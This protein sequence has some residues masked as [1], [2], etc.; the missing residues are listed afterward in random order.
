[1]AQNGTPPSAKKVF[2]K[3]YAEAA[4]G[5]SPEGQLIG[6][7][8]DIFRRQRNN[9]I[10]TEIQ[11][12]L[13]DNQRVLKDIDLSNTPQ[14][15]IYACAAFAIMGQ[16]EDA[17]KF[18]DI[19]FKSDAVWAFFSDGDKKF[20]KLVLQNAINQITFHLGLGHRRSIDLIARAMF[21]TSDPFLIGDIEKRCKGT[22]LQAYG[23]DIAMKASKIF[24]DDSYVAQ[25]AINLSD[26]T[27][28]ILTLENFCVIFPDN[29]VMHNT[30]ANA[31]IHDD[32][33][34]EAVRLL[35]SK[36]KDFPDNAV[37]HN[38]LANAYIHDDR[39]AEAVRLLVS[40]IK[41]FPDNAVMHATLANAYIHDNRPAEAVRLLAP[42]IKDFPDNA[43]MHNTLANAYIHDGRP[44]E[45]VRLLAPRIKDFPD[46]AVMHTTLANAYIHDNRPA[47][48]VQLL[49]PRIKDFPD[50]AVMHTTLAMC[51][52]EAKMQ[53]IFDA[54]KPK[55]DMPQAQIDYLDAKIAYLSNDVQKAKSI[56]KPYIFEQ[57]ECNASSL[58]LY[59]ACIGN[60][61]GIHALLPILK[62]QYTYNYLTQCRDE[63]REN[64][65]RDMVAD[66][67][68]TYSSSWRI[69]E[70]G[71]NAAASRGDR[72][73]AS[74]FA[75][76]GVK[77]SSP[78][79]GRTLRL[80][81]QGVRRPKT[82]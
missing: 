80:K 48:A 76:V 34:A 57:T 4:F 73:S 1:M 74:F 47:K 55:L 68:D 43:V 63:W 79:S 49:A 2:E 12:W 35:V 13:R 40:K 32:R 29:A 42:R 58:G 10:R 11:Q 38:T 56:L 60:D 71:V 5:N 61:A 78:S 54:I 30:L 67:T 62:G 9:D 70:Q 46:N 59:L 24:P 53:T 50:G 77:S 28:F 41:D 21:V 15:A 72:N 64:P 31:Y 6:S 26:E 16:K 27:Q 20:Q 19:C 18:L 7:L 8:N 14:F 51:A 44:A 69:H 3:P 23:Y 66:A 81:T 52:V 75:P 65:L 45:A 39:P 25:A 37:M 33:P 22:G 17:S 36:I 82:P